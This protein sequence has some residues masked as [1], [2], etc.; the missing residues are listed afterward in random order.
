MRVRRPPGLVLEL[1]WGSAKE[2]ARAEEEGEGEGPGWRQRLVAPAKA[3]PRSQPPEG[4][5]RPSAR[6]R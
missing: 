5:G 3:E 2:W 6:P 4:S 1:V